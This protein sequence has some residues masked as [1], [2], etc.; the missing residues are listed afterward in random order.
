MIN[1]LYKM[2]DALTS[3]YSSKDRTNLRLNSP[4]ETNIGK[5]FSIISWGFDKVQEQSELI[6]LWDNID[7]AKGEVLDRYGRNFGV[8]RLGAT[9]RYYRLSIKIDRKSVV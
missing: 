2:L 6:K 8:Q 3:A 9:D 4:I 7:N 5:L 1:F